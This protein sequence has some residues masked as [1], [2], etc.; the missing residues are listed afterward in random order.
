MSNT[1]F[2]Q[3][4]QQ[5]TSGCKLN[6][7]QMTTSRTMTPGQIQRVAELFNAEKDS[8]GGKRAILNR[9]HELIAP[10]YQA[11]RSA[12]AF[13]QANSID[14]P[15]RGLRLVKLSRIP[16]L[17]EKIGGYIEELNEALRMLDAGW[18]SVKE[19]AKGRLE[20]LYMEEDYAIRPS[21]AFGIELTFPAIQPDSRL[22]QLHPELY[23]REQERIAARFSEALANAEAAAVDTLQTMIAHFIERLTPSED[24]KKK[25]LSTSAIE[26]IRE[27]VG[28]FRE[29]SI[30]SNEQLEQLVD[31][32]DQICEGIDIKAIRKAGPEDRGQVVD[33]MNE[34]LS[35][36]DQIVIDR[37]IRELELE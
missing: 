18:E 6:T 23:Q 15:E 31:Q 20:E 37:P 32:V 36:I 13:I 33:A 3:Q 10:V 14:Y 30:G 27:F 2:A 7:Y 5:Q 1:E 17:Q 24:G 16:Y 12:R 26:N 19:E 28:N 4:L 22:M 29:L 11:L 9:K 25:S 35:K 21:Q 8:V 34:L